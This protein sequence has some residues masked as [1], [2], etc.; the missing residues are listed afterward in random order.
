MTTSEERMVDIEAVRIPYPFIRATTGSVAALADSIRED[1]MRH[2]IT[3]W[4]DGTLISGLRRHRARLL[5]AHKEVRVVFVDTIEDA[6]KRLQIDEEDT[7]HAVP[8][9]PSELCRLWGLLR[10]LDAPAALA[11][12]EAARR[13]GAELRLAN[14]QGKRP[15]GRM[16]Q[17]TDDYVLSVIGPAFGMSETTA[18]R[19]WAIHAMA[20]GISKGRSATAERRVIA[21]DAMRSLDA[22]Q[23]TIWANYARMMANRAAP[24][25]VPRPAVPVKSAPV[26]EQLAAW[27]RAL[28]RMEG[29]V[30]GLT[31]LGPPN[32]AV[33]PEHIVPVLDRLKV[34]RRNIEKIINQ[35]RETT[36]P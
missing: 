10:T 30:L 23:G 27:E 29:L 12:H 36:K 18:G 13:R 32:A 14:K 25:S 11:R 31:E 24:V 21:Q 17:R 7:H 35:M 2:P 22:G 19:L 16:R 8:L 20:N 9:K 33:P 34:V 1:K 6:A 5:L 3:L 4:S 15:A 26:A 28:P